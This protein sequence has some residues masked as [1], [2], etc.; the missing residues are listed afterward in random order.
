MLTQRNEVNLVAAVSLESRNDVK[1]FGSAIYASLNVPDEV[2][3]ASKW[4]KKKRDEVF[5][6]LS[7]DVSK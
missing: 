6:M 3:E 4:Q 2:T 1:S 7:V 5:K